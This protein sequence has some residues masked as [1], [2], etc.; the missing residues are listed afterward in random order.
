MTDKIKENNFELNSTEEILQALKKGE[1]VIIMDDEDRENEGDLIK[2][3]SLIEPE[4]INFMI[5]HARGLVCLTLVEGQCKKLGLEP[6][7][8]DNQENF[9]TNFT[10][11]IEASKGVT[12]GISA[13]DRAVTIK[14]ASSPT[15]SK[16]DITTPGHIF[17]LM[18]QKGGVLVR[19]G[20]TEAG[21]DLARLA[22]FEPSASIVEIINQDGTMAR[23]NDLQ[24]FA[25]EHSLK[26]GTIS[27][28]IAYRIQREKNVERVNEFSINTKYGKLKAIE[29]KDTLLN[30]HH[31]ALVH[32]KI[33]KEF[34]SIRVH[35]NLKLSDILNSDIDS[36]WSINESL[37]YITKQESGALVI[38]ESD[39]CKIDILGS[40]KNKIQTNKSKEQEAK[41]P[42]KEVGIGSQI[43]KDLGVEKMEFL[44]KGIRYNALSGFGLTIEKYIPNSKSAK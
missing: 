6:M 12:T 3:A 22:G 37:E 20:H 25:K 18:A 26:I 39:K 9:K 10:I 2:V 32:G 5:T 33:N 31:L 38:L 44:G 1:M 43:L 11:S 16:K 23:R 30:Q 28:L 34:T 41:H 8:N 14:T 15:S 42:Y 24:K 36:S 19:A 29:Y 21:C 40:I 7:S 13:Q 17:P 4:D 35:A 27:D